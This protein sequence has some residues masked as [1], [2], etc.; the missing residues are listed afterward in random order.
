MHAKEMALPINQLYDTRND[1]LTF[2]MHGSVEERILAIQSLIVNFRDKKDF[3]L[4]W[5][6]FLSDDN[7]KV[8]EHA[9]NAACYCSDEKGLYKILKHV[10]ENE[11]ADYHLYDIKT[12]SVHLLNLHEKKIKEENE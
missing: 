9:L 5:E 6:I 4:Y 11:R 2:L 10:L 1:A 12:V 8:R 7:Y 3:D